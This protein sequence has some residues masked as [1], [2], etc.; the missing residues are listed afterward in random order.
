MTAFPGNAASANIGD[1]AAIAAAQQEIVADLRAGRRLSHAHKEGGTTIA[2]EP[3][4]FTIVDYGDWNSR[5]EYTEEATFLAALWKRYDWMVSAERGKQRRS[6][7]ET[8]RFILGELRRECFARAGADAKVVHRLRGLRTAAALVVLALAAGTFGLVR[9]FQVRTI[10]APFGASVLV[11]DALATLTRT[12]EPFL[13]SLHR[14][15]DHDRFRID[16]LVTPL[17]PAAKPRRIPLAR[18]LDR[19]ALHPGTKLL[20]LDGP[21]LWMLVP[22][23]RAVDTRSDR[24]VTL[25]GL[26]AANPQLADVWTTARV[27]FDEGLHLVSADRQRAYTIDPDTLR[28]RPEMTAPRVAWQNPVATVDAYLC[29]AG[30]I[31]S[32]TWVAMLTSS[33]RDATFRVGSTVF[34]NPPLLKTREPRALHRIRMEQAGSRQRVAA[35]DAISG[36]GRADGALVRSAPE[37]GPFV[38]SEPASV[39][40]TSQL[41]SRLNPIVGLSRLALDGR[42]LWSIDTG[43]REFEQVISRPDRVVL[44]GNL[45]SPEGK[46]PEPV[47]VVVEM[48]TGQSTTRTLRP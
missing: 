4:R 1:Q 47:A 17:D 12:Q 29:L 26:Q 24:V 13:P 5:T 23:L 9:V 41:G 6:E 30:P 15:P 11:G 31:D 10:G 3:G 39:L 42:T 2:W 21:L 40:V 38:S 33:E 43:L 16:L 45:P 37:R 27:H 46:V 48:A 34:S 35:V 36:E 14:N 22:E 44:L 28:A 25:R 19:A 7:L 20:G 18:D 8:W 32:E